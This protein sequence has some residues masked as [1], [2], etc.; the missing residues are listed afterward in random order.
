MHHSALEQKHLIEKDLAL[1]SKEER[2]QLEEL[3]RHFFFF[4]GFPYT[5]F[6]SKPMSIGRL[7]PQAKVGWTAWEKIAPLFSSERFVIRKYT[8]NQGEFVLVANLARIEEVYDENRAILSQALGGPVDIAQLKGCLKEDSPLFLRLMDNH[9]ALGV[10]LGYGARNA[11]LFSDNNQMLG[12]SKH[13]LTPF[14]GTHPIF[15][16]FSPVLPLN[17]ACDRD[18][19]ETRELK[20]RYSK[21]RTELVRW[22]KEEDLF[23]RMLL[24]LKS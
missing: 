11:Q 2:K 5:F 9:F 4:D 7:L 13:G 20:N 17:F 15:H 12:K 23:I 10:F 6:G 19:A 21:E 1:L 18:S 3:F 14:S 24:L 16:Y 22:A 8:L